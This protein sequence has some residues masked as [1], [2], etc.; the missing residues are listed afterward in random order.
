MPTLNGRF[1]FAAS[2]VWFASTMALGWAFTTIW[3]YAERLL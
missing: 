3:D 2:F 1:W